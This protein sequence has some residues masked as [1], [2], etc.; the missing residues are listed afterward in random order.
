MEK[1]KKNIKRT[2]MS[3]TNKKE[4]RM[5]KEKDRTNKIRKMKKRVCVCVKRRQIKRK[6]TKKK[7]R[8]INYK[9]T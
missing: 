3:R 5:V 9:F 6:N 4:G 8:K 1:E 7:N 2:D